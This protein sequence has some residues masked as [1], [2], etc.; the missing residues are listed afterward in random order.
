M[1]KKIPGGLGCIG[2]EISY[3]IIWGFLIRHLIRIPTNQAVQ[4]KVGGF[5]RSSVDLEGCEQPTWD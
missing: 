3:P 1:N 2:D 5:V 4:L